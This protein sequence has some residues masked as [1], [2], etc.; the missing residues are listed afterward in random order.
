M[1]LS[2]FIESSHH[3]KHV[4]SAACNVTC[5]STFLFFPPD[6]TVLDVPRLARPPGIAGVNSTTA[7]VTF[8]SWDGDTDDGSPDFPVTGYRVLYRAAVQDAEWHVVDSPGSHSGGK[9]Q[10]ESMQ[11]R[12]RKELELGR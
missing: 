12:N 3:G 4:T 7:L 8:S 2:L 10:K 9:W 6:G 5:L 11:R 1:A